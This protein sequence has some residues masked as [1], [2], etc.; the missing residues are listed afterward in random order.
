MNQSRE[1]VGT[2]MPGPLKRI[3]LRGLTLTFVI[4]AM[5]AAAGF[6]VGLWLGN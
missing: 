1:S 6:G 2:A 3:D 5:A 4:L